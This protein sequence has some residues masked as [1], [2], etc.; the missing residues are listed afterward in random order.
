MAVAADGEGGLTSWPRALEH[1]G[2]VTSRSRLFGGCAGDMGQSRETSPW[3]H[4]PG[5]GPHSRGLGVA[6][7]TLF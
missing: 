6:S 4:S 2:G 7:G 1:A 5:C 3:G